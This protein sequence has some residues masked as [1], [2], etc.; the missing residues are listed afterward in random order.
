MRRIY[1]HPII[2]EQEF[3]ESKEMYERSMTVEGTINKTCFLFLLVTASSILIRLLHLDG[4]TIYGLWAFSIFA[5]I[6]LGISIYIFK[7]IAPYAASFYGIF[8]G[9]AIG[10]AIALSD[11]FSDGFTSHFFQMIF[12]ALFSI[13]VAYRLKII[14]PNNKISLG[15]FTGLGAILVVYLLDFICLTLHLN[16]RFFHKIDIFY[17]IVCIYV[18]V[19][20]SIHLVVIFN[21][22]VEGA[23]NRP[24]KYLEWFAA[25]GLIVTIL[26]VY[27]VAFGR[28]GWRGWRPI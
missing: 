27:I 21:V 24:P 1:W 19:M 11:L 23:N 22:I 20:S 18:V 5:T 26:S 14:N 8:Q 10:G 13:L 15:I 16:V 9:F 25:F 4:V 7:N 3:R 6:V 17:L 12:G 28:R 2:T